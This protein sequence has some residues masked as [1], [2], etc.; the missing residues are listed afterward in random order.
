MARDGDQLTLREV[1]SALWRRKWII[2]A[3]TLLAAVVAAVYLARVEPNYTSTTT[4]RAS[5]FLT[6]SIAAGSIAGVPADVDPSVIT[7]PA[8]LEP[9]AEALDEPVQTVASSVTYEVVEGLRTNSLV[10]TAAGPSSDSAQARA[11]AVMQSYMDYVSQ[12]IAS[13]LTTLQTNVATTTEQIRAYQT[14]LAGN[15]N[16][17]IAAQNLATSLATLSGYNSQ[18]VL[19]QNA[20]SVLTV[21]AAATPGA[22]T[23]PSLLIVAA[24]ALV[25]GLLAGAGIALV[26][27]FFDDRLRSSDEIEPLTGAP[28]IAE[29]AN[30]PRV[31][32]RKVRLP[33]ASAERTALSEGIRSLRTTVQVM[34]PEGKGVIVVTSVEPGDGKTFLSTNLAVSW[35]RAGRKVILVGG[36]LRRGQLG[37]YFPGLDHVA[38]LGNLLSDASSARRAP[39]QTQIIDSLQSTPFRG[40]RVMPSGS[41]TEEPADLLGGRHVGRVITHLARSADVVVIDSPPALALADASE[42]ASHAFGVVLIATVNRTRRALLRDTV[43][44]LRANGIEVLGIVVNRSRRRLPKSYAS[45]Y[46]KRTS[47]PA[48]APRATRSTAQPLEDDRVLLAEDEG[49][50]NAE[51]SARLDAPRSAPATARSGLDE[52]AVPGADPEAIRED[53]AADVDID[54]T[55]DTEH[56]DVGDESLQDRQDEATSQGLRGAR[57]RRDDIDLDQDQHA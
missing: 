25:C 39:S 6:D 13:T 33:A 7:T 50:D 48:A 24:L 38:G 57:R 46:L 47:S 15:P 49:A 21:T 22:S 45:Y 2:V 41:T 51:V 10:V 4:A 53:V 23:N 16:D 32:R 35:A 12:T 5:T 36:D 34:L 52:T 17:P 43:A 28:A 1:L 3:V 54:D 8:V 11:Q 20:G 37:W 44:N 19:I 29:L 30:D 26:R 31:S 18:I 56:A 40:L 42:L 14:Q 55:S 27:D 9:A